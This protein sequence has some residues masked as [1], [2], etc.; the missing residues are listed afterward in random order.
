M[1]QPT[2]NNLFPKISISASRVGKVALLAALSDEKEEIYIK[3]QISSMK[4]LRLAVTFVSGVSDFVKRKFIQSLVGCALNNN[5]IKKKAG[6]IHATIHA[7]LEALG[8]ISSNVPIE[9]SL[10]LKV[11]I[12]RDSQ[13]LA[14]AIYGESAFSPMT[15]HE[16]SCMG[17]MHL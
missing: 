17:V 12:A 2:E 13:W 4:D 10:K 11:A 9:A 15:N 7:G 6:H 16:R 1:T 14:V 5:I 8:G 3:E